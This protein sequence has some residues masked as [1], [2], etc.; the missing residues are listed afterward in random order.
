[1]ALD[2]PT[3]V[4]DV[5]IVAPASADV[6]VRMRTA[7]GR[8][9]R[10]LDSTRIADWCQLRRGRSVCLVTF[11]LLEAQREGLWTV[12]VRKRSDPA[13]TVRVGVI[14][15]SPSPP[16]PHPQAFPPRQPVLRLEPVVR[17]PLGKAGTVEEDAHTFE[18]LLRLAHRPDGNQLDGPN[19]VHGIRLD[20]LA[21]RLADMKR[22]VHSLEPIPTGR[23]SHRASFPASKP[24][25]CAA[26][27]ERESGGRDLNPR[28]L[29]PQPSALPDCATARGRQSR[30]SAV[31]T[32]LQH[33]S[34]GSGGSADPRP[35]R[36]RATILGFKRKQPRSAMNA[37]DA[38]RAVSSLGDWRSP[39]QIRAP[40][41]DE[42]PAQAGFSRHRT[43]PSV[44]A[45]VANP[46]PNASSAALARSI[47]SPKRC[48]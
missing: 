15:R 42:S 35:Y 12:I 5:R 20:P 38:P 37:R 4:F 36:R 2:P 25:V 10:I 40:R 45:A 32:T 44:S 3:H 14:F 39:V 18:P 29:G 41:S 31:A 1:M 48:P 23:Q 34:L 43:P 33:S 21:A 26:D 13:A 19:D 24:V 9:L 7:N 27:E 17:R 30:L 8:L 47:E 16:T 28:P 22:L 46:R 11:P 6:R